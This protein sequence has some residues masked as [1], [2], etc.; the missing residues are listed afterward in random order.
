[1][2]LFGGTLEIMIASIML[3]SSLIAYLIICIPI[4]IYIYISSQIFSIVVVPSEEF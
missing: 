2:V 4:Y 1:M 3:H